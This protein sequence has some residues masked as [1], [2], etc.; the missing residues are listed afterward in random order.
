MQ[1]HPDCESSHSLNGCPPVSYP[2]P[3]QRRAPIIMLNNHSKISVSFTSPP[4]ALSPH[5]EGPG[6]VT[7]EFET[8][9]QFFLVVPQLPAQTV[10]RR[11]HG[12]I[13]P[14]RFPLR[15]SHHCT[16]TP[17]DVQCCLKKLFGRTQLKPPTDLAQHG[18][19]TPMHPGSSCCC[20]C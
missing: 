6:I 15:T 11:H 1:A 19:A 12:I 9:P 3:P 10:G 14:H 18:L 2:H 8:S 7:I 17:P 20:C 16:P 5:L 13:L 4:L